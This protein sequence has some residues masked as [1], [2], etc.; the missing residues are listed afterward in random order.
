MSVPTYLVHGKKLISFAECWV[1]VS[2][3]HDTGLIP[4]DLAMIVTIGLWFAVPWHNLS[5]IGMPSD[6]MWSKPLFA[7]ALVIA[8]TLFQPNGSPELIFNNDAYSFLKVRFGSAVPELLSFS[9][10][11]TFLQCGRFSRLSQCGRRQT[12]T[13]LCCNNEQ[14]YVLFKS[15]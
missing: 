13:R 9:H 11:L 6:P 10:R 1:S 5:I 15:L 4:L 14:M 3:R 7:S 2:L 8:E 12:S